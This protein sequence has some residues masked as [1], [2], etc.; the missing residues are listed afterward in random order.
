MKC[1][2]EFRKSKGFTKP[3]IANILGI[4][5]SLYEKI[6]YSDRKPSRNFMSRFK[7]AFPSFDMNIFL[8]NYYTKRVAKKG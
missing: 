1:L 3:E 2:E 7:L 4:S 8:M 5:L 6:E